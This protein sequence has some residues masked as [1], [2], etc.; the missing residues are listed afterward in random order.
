MLL[1]HGTIVALIDGNKFELF[2]NAG[3]EAEPRLEKQDAPSLDTSNH[4]AGSHHES[5]KGNHGRHK[6]QEEV[7][8]AAAVDWLNRQVLDHR[9]DNLVV[10][11]A[12][13]TLGDMRPHYHRQLQQ[14]LLK[15]LP[16]D[17]TGRQGPEIVAALRGK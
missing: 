5:A 7:H 16:K 1:P 11:A 14:V 13:R 15:E 2:R 3:N 17:L 10:I 12:P 9:I 6:E 8:S 4:S